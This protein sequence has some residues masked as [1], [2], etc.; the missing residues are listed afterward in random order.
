M[1]IF[2]HHV[3]KE[4]AEKDFPKTVYSSISI[5]QVISLIP[6]NLPYYSKIFQELSSIFPDGHCNCWGVPSGAT[7][8]ITKL[9]KG[10][11]IFLVESISASI[12]ENGNVPVLGIIKYFLPEEIPYLSKIL[13]GELNFPYIFFFKTLR[14]NLTWN[15]FL[16]IIN[17]KTNFNPNGMVY[18]ISDSRLDELGGADRIIKDIIQ[19]YAIYSD[20]NV[21]AERNVDY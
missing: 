10:D 9:K 18:K 11:A 6:D 15:K 12:H 2:F 1:Q 7:R 19:K 13:W 5:I 8:I 17:Y 21:V 20:K 14:L 3:G 16:E 4:G